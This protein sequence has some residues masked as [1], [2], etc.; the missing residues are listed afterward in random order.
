MTTQD[1]YIFVKKY[2]TTDGIEDFKFVDNTLEDI[3]IVASQS[4]I[5]AYSQYS[6]GQLFYTRD[7]GLFY[8]LDSAK[9]NLILSDTYK[10]YIGRNGIKFRYLHSADYNKRI[11]PAASN[12]VDIHLLT[13]AYDITYRQWLAGDI[14][15]KF[16]QSTLYRHGT[17][18]DKINHKR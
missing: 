18:L 6:V 11:D 13:R 17:E 16:I 12:L 10:G 5:G 8:Q 9:A 3:K 7:T 14:T 4:A 15:N 2:I 1:K